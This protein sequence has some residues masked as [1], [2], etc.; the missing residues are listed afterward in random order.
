MIFEHLIPANTIGVSA[1]LNPVTGA[2]VVQDVSRAVYAQEAAAPTA[3]VLVGYVPATSD[4]NGGIKQLAR[5]LNVQYYSQKTTGFSVGLSGTTLTIVYPNVP[6]LWNG[7]QQTLAAGSIPGTVSTGVW[8]L[9]VGYQWGLTLVS[10]VQS[11]T[12]DPTA[13]SIELCQVTVNTS[14]NTAVVSNGRVSG[15]W[16][17]SICIAGPASTSYSVSTSNASSVLPW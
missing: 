3:P 15:K 9:V 7:V 2:F 4:G 6:V 14:L 1:P 10:I 16:L 5:H 8:S 11:S 13:N 17:G 12:V